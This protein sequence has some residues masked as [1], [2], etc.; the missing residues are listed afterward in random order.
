M[1]KQRVAFLPTTKRLLKKFDEIRC[2]VLL[3]STL[4]LKNVW[5]VAEL[6]GKYQ[7]FV[8]MIWICVGL[9]GNILPEKC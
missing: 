5:I 7:G 8:K 2:D 6:P 1:K 3:C 4:H 9:C